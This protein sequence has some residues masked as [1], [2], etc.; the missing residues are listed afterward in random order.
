MLRW[1]V[2]HFFEVNILS[3]EL[4]EKFVSS[5][6]LKNCGQTAQVLDSTS[7]TNMQC[8]CQTTESAE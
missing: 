5:L 8:V 2:Y 6:I 3:D 4:S 7:T 1:T